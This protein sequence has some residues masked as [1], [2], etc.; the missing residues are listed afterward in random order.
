LKGNYGGRIPIAVIDR[1]ANLFGMTMAL[2]GE[3][4]IGDA[5]GMRSTAGV[6]IVEESKKQLRK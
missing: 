6:G 5:T 2:N 1:S 3:G 4:Q